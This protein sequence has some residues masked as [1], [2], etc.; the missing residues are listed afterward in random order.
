MLSRLTFTLSLSNTN[1]DLSKRM[2]LQP[3]QSSTS[4]GSA[5]SGGNSA[6]PASPAGSLAFNMSMI[7]FLAGAG[8][9]VLATGALWAISRNRRKSTLSATPPVPVTTP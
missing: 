8:I 1:L 9:A 7:Y 2:A 4:T 3:T 6:N 5:T